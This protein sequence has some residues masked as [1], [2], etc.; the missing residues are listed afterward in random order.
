MVKTEA[1]QVFV[2]IE[3]S[4]YEKRKYPCS[5]LAL[6]LP[7]PPPQPIKTVPRMVLGDDTEG[8]VR[9]VWDVAA[10]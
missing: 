1:I 2:H 8:P 10:H 7:Q 3:H 4:M 5:I 6:P 9:S